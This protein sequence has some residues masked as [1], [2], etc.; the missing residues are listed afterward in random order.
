[1]KPFHRLLTS[2]VAALT[3]AAATPA[4]ASAPRPT[5]VVFTPRP[6]P[7]TPLPVIP[8][9]SAPALPR[10]VPTMPVPPDP[11]CLPVE[12]SEY[13]I[14]ASPI[15]Y[16]FAV[17]GT[18]RACAPVAVG[19]SWT[20]ATFRTGGPGAA[21]GPRSFLSLAGP[22]VTFTF[23]GGGGL[24]TWAVCVVKNLRPA[25]EQPDLRVADP[26]G[27]FGPGE[28]DGVL[29]AVPVPVDDPRFAGALL[30]PPVDLSRPVCGSCLVDVR[31]IP[32]P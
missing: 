17:S 9:Q 26:M 11:A 10:P 2:V 4:L 29:T 32:T 25:P 16:T 14:A 21:Y 20:I 8:T 23:E 27:C 30:A 13:G 3:V 1:M 24:D 15:Q 22:Q 12:F 18:V 19:A 28:V 31:P 6:V 7:T 5:P